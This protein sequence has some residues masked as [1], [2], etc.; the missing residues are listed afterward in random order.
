MD[1]DRNGTPKEA[2]KKD[3]PL[4]PLQRMVAQAMGEDRT[5]GA[6]NDPAK[7]RYPAL[8]EFL[9]TVY[10]SETRMKTPCKLTVQL[11]PG[12]VI[13]SLTDPDMK[14]SLQVAFPH[15]V[16]LLEEMERAA[17]DPLA[18]WKSWGKGEPELRKRKKRDS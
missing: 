7:E 5:F 18:P 8:W 11:G 17:A 3:R 2:K 14:Q 4:S 6:E 12:G 1:T 13:C 9:A 10:V 15:L 16:N